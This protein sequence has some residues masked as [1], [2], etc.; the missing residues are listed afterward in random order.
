M[1]Q[2]LFTTNDHNKLKINKI[3]RDINEHST[4]IIYI[5]NK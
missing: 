4:Y 1:Y 5:Y 2:N 3:E